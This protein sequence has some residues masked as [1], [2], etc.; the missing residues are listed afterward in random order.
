MAS[1]FYNE[2]QNVEDQRVQSS[3]FNFSLPKNNILGLLQ[4]TTQAV[5]DGNGYS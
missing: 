2:L 1:I 5:A 3:L 4:Q